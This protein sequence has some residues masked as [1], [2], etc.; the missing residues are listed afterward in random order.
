MVR[1]PLARRIPGNDRL[2]SVECVL[3]FF[4]RKTA[5]AVAEVLLGKKAEGDDG[6]GDTGGGEGRR[7]LDRAGDMEVNASHPGPPSG[8]PSTRLPSADACRARPAKP[9]K[10]LTALAQALSRD[11]LRPDARK[12]AYNELFGVLDGLAGPAQG[13]GRGGDI[14]HP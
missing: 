14:R 1:T 6:S 2:N 5:T 11:G 3:P 8:R 13:Q 12:D 9:I 4:N 7:V 10:R